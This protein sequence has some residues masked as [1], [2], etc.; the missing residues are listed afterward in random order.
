MPRSRDKNIPGIL[1]KFRRVSFN[2]AEQIDS[3]NSMAARQFK[4]NIVGTPAQFG[5]DLSSVSFFFRAVKFQ[6]VVMSVAVMTVVP[7]NKRRAVITM[8]RRKSGEVIGTPFEFTIDKPPPQFR[9]GGDFAANVFLRQ[10]VDERLRHGRNHINRQRQHNN[11][12]PV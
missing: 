8:A 7:V 3:A 11:Q 12:P 6:P 5:D 10:R 1:I 4:V 2:I 9:N